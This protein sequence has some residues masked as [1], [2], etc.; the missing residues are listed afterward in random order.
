MA[1]FKDLQDVVRYIKSLD[2]TIEKAT[3]KA[4]LATS[5]AAEGFAKKN[6]KKQFTGR[7]GR[8][9]GGS[10]LNNIYSGLEE[11]N[12]R[13][14]DIFAGVRT[15][16]YGAIHEFGSKDLPGGVITPVKAKK[17]WIPQYPAAK[18]MSPRDF[19]KA[20]MQNPTMYHIFAKVAAMA[21][22]PKIPGTKQTWVP[23]FYLVDKVKIPER[24]YIRP[25]LQASM[26]VFPTYMEKYINE[27]V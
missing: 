14:P 8:T 7:N 11:G 27:G 4:L 15:I 24:P 1:M 20:A 6:S 9:L 12:G 19:V 18:K 13:F 10:L 16:P 2:P 3:L 22:G 17:L 21:V 5:V 23:I 26:E 25:A